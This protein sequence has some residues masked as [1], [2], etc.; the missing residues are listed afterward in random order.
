LTGAGA[1][2]GDTLP[3]PHRFNEAPALQRLGA[4]LTDDAAKRA[5]ERAVGTEE[6]ALR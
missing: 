1:V 3:F 2:C 6:G 4:C 5:V